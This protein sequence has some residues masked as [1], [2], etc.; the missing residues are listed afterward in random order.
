[1]KLLQRVKTA[2]AEFGFAPGCL[3]LAD[4]ALSRIGGGVYWYRL[5]AQPVAARSQLGTRGSTIDVRQVGGSD[6]ELLQM[7]KDRRVVEYRVAQNAI[8]FGAFKATQMIGYLWLCLGPYQEDEVRCIFTPSPPG[9][10]VWD[11]DIYFLPEHRLGLGF[12]RLWDEANRFLRG[13]GVAW[14]MSRIS[15]FKSH[16]LASHAKLGARSVGSALFIRIGKVQLAFAT[17]P[18]HVHFSLSPKHRPE[19]VIGAPQLGENEPLSAV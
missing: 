19:Y 16:S 15:G 13:Q 14:S 7:L 9:R 5:T 4:R 12:L 18:P 1:M 2:I 8:C 11:F 17:V 6:P 10:A 3:Y